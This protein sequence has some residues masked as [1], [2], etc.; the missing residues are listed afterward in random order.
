MPAFF[1]TASEPPTL[2]GKKT[3]VSGHDP[4]AHAVPDRY[5]YSETTT[6]NPL[7]KEFLE[8]GQ[9]VSQPF[10]NSDCGTFFDVG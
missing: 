5:F 6:I 8:R 1:S 10:G 7:T 3:L 4:S 2:L 9:E